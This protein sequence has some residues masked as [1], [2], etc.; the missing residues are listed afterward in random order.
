MFKM[1]KKTDKQM[2]VEDGE[3]GVVKN[4]E[5]FINPFHQDGFNMGTAL[6][7]NLMIMHENH[8]TAI[9]KWIRLVNLKTG[10]TV[11]IEISDEVDEKNDIKDYRKALDNIKIRAYELG[12][13]EIHDMAL[14]AL[15]K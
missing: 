12:I 5:G 9:C 14:E 7:K 15:K 6:G 8:D 3:F 1:I 2:S 11:D 4:A 10:E 13:K